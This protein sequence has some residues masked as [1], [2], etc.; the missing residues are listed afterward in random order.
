MIK[1]NPYR[2]TLQ[3]IIL[4][5]A[6]QLKTPLQSNIRQTLTVIRSHDLNLYLTR[7]LIYKSDGTF[8]D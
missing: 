5:H 3:C 7:K 2:P 4:K 1:L 6:E 8:R